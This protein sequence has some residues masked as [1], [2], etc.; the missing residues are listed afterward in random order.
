MEEQHEFRASTRSYREKLRLW[1]AYKFSSKHRGISPQY[2]DPRQ[3]RDSGYESDISTSVS[4]IQSEPDY[5]P[6]PSNHTWPGYWSS[7]PSTLQSYPEIFGPADRRQDISSFGSSFCTC[8]ARCPAHRTVTSSPPPMSADMDIEVRSPNPDLA[9]ARAL[10]S[11]GPQQS[12]RIDS[13]LN[14]DDPSPNQFLSQHRRAA[15]DG[16]GLK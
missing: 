8:R 13:I 6:N 7:P 15:T 12:F 14:H 5:R 3:R 4:S 16:I 2:T 9:A 1:N 10:L 11:L